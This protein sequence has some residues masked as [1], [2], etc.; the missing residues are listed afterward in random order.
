MLRQLKKPELLV[1]TYKHDSSGIAR[2]AIAETERPLALSI[3]ELQ[4]VAVNA[5]GEVTYAFCSSETLRDS[6]V[7][8]S[9]DI[10]GIAMHVNYCWVA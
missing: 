3:Q 8:R 1:A 6:T 9:S 10:R 7:W 5:G 4:R 2:A